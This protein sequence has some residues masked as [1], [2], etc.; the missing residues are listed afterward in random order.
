MILKEKDIR[1]EYL[2]KKQQKFIRQDINY[3]KK[4]KRNFIKVNCPACDSRSSNFFLE[5]NSFKYQICNKCDTFYISPRPKLSLL[6]MFYNLSLNGKFWHEYMF[7]LTNDI[8]AKKIFKPRVNKI[9]E[10]SKKYKFKN[11]S[12]L[13]VGA[14]YGT[15]CS[16]AQK[17]NFFS[18]VTAIEPSKYGSENCKK[19][20]VEVFHGMVE[21]I[22]NLKRKYDIV[23]SFEVIE[24]LYSI[25]NYIK[26]IKKY[27]KPN[28]LLII[29]C[30]NG[31]GFDV[32]FLLKN[33][34]T[35]D[36]E[37]LNYF[38]PQSIILALKKLKLDVKEIFTPGKLDLDIVKNTLKNKKINKTSNYFFD[39]LIFNENK[40]LAKNFQKFLVENNLSSN[41]WVV[42]KFN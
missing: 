33:S 30:P 13:D 1:P 9:I 8:R 25:K 40:Q 4:N 21:N 24:H 36:H 10:L 18:K 5:K 38:N 20:G 11:P 6:K 39:K 41:M 32:R 35:I 7:P 17:T 16:E 22:S 42:A 3:L 27:I 23:T 31:D 12:I 26:Q 37:H 34:D 29:T 19:N 2:R 28:G 14:G 15:F